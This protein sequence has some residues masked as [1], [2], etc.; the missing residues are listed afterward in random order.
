M[1]ATG[2]AVKRL[3]RYQTEEKLSETPHSVRRRELE[4]SSALLSSAVLSFAVLPSAARTGGSQQQQ[5][6]RQ[7]RRHSHGTASIWALK[8]PLYFGVQRSNCKSR[9][10]PA[11]IP[12]TPIDMPKTSMPLALPTKYGITATSTA[13]NTARPTHISRTLHLLTSW[14]ASG[15]T[16]TITTTTHPT[17]EQKTDSP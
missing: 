16:V 9:W 14:H 6:S 7:P 11:A 1:S 13:E 3:Y 5:E 8:L 2:S 15:R 12:P 4:I 10:T 17:T